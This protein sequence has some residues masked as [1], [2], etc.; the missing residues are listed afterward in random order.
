MRRKDIYIFDREISI[1]I[2][3]PARGATSLMVFV[4]TVNKRFQSTHPRGVRHFS[5]YCFFI[6]Y[7][8]QSTHPRGV[9]HSCITTVVSYVVLFQSTHPRGVRRVLPIL[10]QNRRYISIHAPARGATIFQ[11][12]PVVL[13]FISIHAPARGA[14][15]SI[16]DG[17]YRY[18]ISIHAPARGATH[19]CN[20]LF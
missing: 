2:H 10:G 11:K 15:N 20:Y 16:F 17:I 8:F 5:R 18:I 3:A 13:Y 6:G 14:T 19:N 12:L 4:L 9:R 7:K 1:S